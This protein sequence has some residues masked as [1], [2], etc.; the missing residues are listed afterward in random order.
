MYSMRISAFNASSNDYSLDSYHTGLAGG[1]ASSSEHNSRFSSVYQQSGGKANSSDY[2][3][4]IGFFSQPEFCGD[5]FC[6]NNEDCSS[7]SSDCG[8]CPSPAPSAPSAAAAGAAA[9]TYDWVCSEWYPE[10]CPSEGVQKRVCVNRGTCEGTVGMPS[11]IKTCI[12]EFIP[13][14]EPLFDLFLRIP[15]GKK[16]ISRGDN[17]ETQIELI[18]IGNITTIDVLFKYWI[19]DENNRLIL[20]KQETRAIGEREKFSAWFDISK[21]TKPG[22]YKVYVHITYDSKVALAGDSFEIFESRLL[23][24]RRIVFLSLIALSVLSGLIIIIIKIFRRKERRKRKVKRRE[25]T[26]LTRKLLRIKRK[27]ARKIKRRRR[28]KMREFRRA[29]RKRKRRYR[30]EKRKEK[31]MIRRIERKRKWKGRVRKRKMMLM[32]VKKK[33]RMRKRRKK[34]KKPPRVK[35]EKKKPKRKAVKIQKEEGKLSEEIERMRKKIYLD[36][37]KKTVEMKKTSKKISKENL[38]P[39]V[40]NLRGEIRKKGIKETEMHKKKRK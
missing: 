30:I 15:F 37:L 21:D 1:N 27:R 22:V 39:K 3:A 32:R 16:W 29:K 20:E 5:G 26:R 14:S 33:R 34:L 25:I 31:R 36:L 12:P 10:P 17:L 13:P 28:K 23:I 8:S 9:C 2:T 18:N 38:N 11:L 4:N 24:T 7:C 40:E 6:N 19:V 35:R